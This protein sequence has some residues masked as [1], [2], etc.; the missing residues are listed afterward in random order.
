MITTNIKCFK[1]KWLLTFKTKQEYLIFIKNKLPYI[2]ILCNEDCNIIKFYYKFKQKKSKISLLKS[3]QGHKK[4]F[5]QYQH[6]QY[7]CIWNFFL[8]KKNK[9]FFNLLY[10]IPSI[11]SCQEYLL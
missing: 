5:S 6:I 8:L 1:Y 2:F 9:K 3:P 11:Y 4:A 7:Y 10:S